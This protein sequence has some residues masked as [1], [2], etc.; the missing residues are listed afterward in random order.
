MWTFTGRMTGDTSGN[1]VLRACAVETHMDFAEEH[2][3]WTFAGK[4]TGDTSGDS[5]LCEPAQSKRA[6]TFPKSHFAW[7]F[8]GI[9]PHAPA[10]TSIK[11]RALTLTVRTR[12]VW[13]HCLWNLHIHA[14]IHIHIHLHRHIH[15]LKHIYI[16]TY[17]DAGISLLAVMHHMMYQL[18]YILLTHIHRVSNLSNI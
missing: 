1:S 18:L 15:I 13:P 12:S 11:H 7:K 3:V 5:V 17:T 4:M 8:T 9:M 6:W 2:F 10:T 14:H 16:Y